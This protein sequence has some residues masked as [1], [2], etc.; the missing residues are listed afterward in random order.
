MEKKN[1]IPMDIINYEWF[2]CKSV[3]RMDAACGNPVG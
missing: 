1:C 2:S 3:T